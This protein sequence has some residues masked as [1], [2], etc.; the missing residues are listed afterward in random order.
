MNKTIEINPSLFSLS[1]K[2]KKEKKPTK[3][4]P[5]ISPNIIKKKL[6]K[7][8][9]QHKLD[10][11]KNIQNSEKDKNSKNSKNSKNDNNNF[12]TDHS[13]T[14]GDDFENSLEYLQSLAKQNQISHTKQNLEKKTV[15]N[16]QNIY[17]T[18]SHP[19]EQ[20]NIQIDLPDDM[21]TQLPLITVNTESIRLKDDVPYGNLKNGSK[22]TYRIWNK[23]HKNPHTIS[24]NPST[25]NIPISINPPDIKLEN[26]IYP[27]ELNERE[28][29]LTLLK[30]KINEKHSLN[31][32]VEN[33][34][35]EEVNIK[36]K[37]EY[38]F[39]R[40]TIKT[41]KKKYT[42]GKSKKRREI[43]ILL[44]S[45]GTRKKILDACKDLRKKPT[46]EITNYL[47]DHNLIKLGSNAPN[48][49]IRNLYESAMMTG[50]ITN[51]NNEIMMD[52]FLKTDSW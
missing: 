11:I 45:N 31:L 27:T 22:P 41:I 9:K 39:N 29:K 38:P 20:N 19:I 44:K 46:N 36:P 6:L 16:Y 35:I 3:Q 2:P 15:K 26:N 42:L 7:R 34:N 8:I 50:E 47:R 25:Y 32:P 43:S 49:I 37:L 24:S 28:R 5:A 18:S 1:S 30:E 52:N 33:S 40:K 51:L 21:K 13:N 14:F 4:R 23:T 12:K 17:N 10:E 48:N